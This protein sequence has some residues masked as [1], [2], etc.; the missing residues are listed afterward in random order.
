MLLQIALR[1]QPRP[2]LGGFEFVAHFKLPPVYI[3]NLLPQFGQGGNVVVR[4]EVR[5]LC[6]FFQVAD[7]RVTGLAPAAVRNV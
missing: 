5:N 2:D 7:S 1:E 6:R 4:Q 3:R